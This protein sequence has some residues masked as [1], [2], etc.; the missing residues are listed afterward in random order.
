MISIPSEAGGYGQWS[1]NPIDYVSLLAECVRVISDG[2]ETVGGITVTADPM[3][4]KGMMALHG[5]H[6]Q[7]MKIVNIGESD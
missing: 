7:V 4:P 6:G 5:S 2:T 3:M 1:M